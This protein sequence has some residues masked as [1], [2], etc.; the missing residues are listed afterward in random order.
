MSDPRQ[1]D[2][3]QRML[4]ALLARTGTQTADFA[5]VKSALEAGR[6]DIVVELPWYPDGG[7]HQ[8]ILQALA[9]DRISVVN[10]LGHAGHA[11]GDELVDGGIVRQAEAGNIESVRL[12]DLEA[13]FKQGLAR[14]LLP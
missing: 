7:T 9:G 13:L 2:Q 11:I 10:P 3:T 12:G 4:D 1:L 6:R 5:V 14:A 8:L